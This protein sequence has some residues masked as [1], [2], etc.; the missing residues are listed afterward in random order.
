MHLLS[1]LTSSSV[2]LGV[3]ERTPWDNWI[4]TDFG[5]PKSRSFQKKLAFWTVTWSLLSFVTFQPQ[6]KLCGFNSV[7]R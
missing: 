5:M 1:S 3:L 7:F 4:S 2:A 6:D